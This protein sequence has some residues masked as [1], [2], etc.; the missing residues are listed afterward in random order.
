ML[1]LSS[2][3]AGSTP[4]IQKV[5]KVLQFG[6]KIHGKSYSKCQMAHFQENDK[7]TVQIDTKKVSFETLDLSCA[8]F[9]II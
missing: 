2:Y 5:S 3:S 4:R 9:E 6:R 1:R 7:M 8:G